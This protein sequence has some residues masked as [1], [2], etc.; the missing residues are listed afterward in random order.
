MTNTPLQENIM[1]FPAITKVISVDNELTPWEKAR[2]KAAEQDTTPEFHWK[3]RITMYHNIRKALNYSAIWSIFEVTH[4]DEIAFNGYIKALHYDYYGTD[5]ITIGIDKVDPTWFDIY[6]A[7]NDAIVESH[8]H[9][10]HHL[11]IE[12]VNRTEDRLHLFTGS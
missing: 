12:I 8:K 2:M 11:Y 9:D 3:H 7:C 4:F 5:V 6:K 1:D 10:N